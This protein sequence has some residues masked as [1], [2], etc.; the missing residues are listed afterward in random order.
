MLKVETGAI[1]ELIQDEVSLQVQEAL[2]DGKWLVSLEQRIT[3]F[4][5]G[6]ITKRFANID[7]VPDLVKSVETSVEK[8]FND[9]FIP[10]LHHLVNTS[11]L[12]NAVDTAIQ[13]QIATTIDQLIINDEWIKKIETLVNNNFARKIQNKIN[14]VDFNLLIVEQIDKGV[15]R[16]QDKLLDQL[17]TQG[18]DDQAS[19]NVL[20]LNDLGVDI[21]GELIADS[22]DIS[23][24]TVSNALVVNDLVVKNSVNTDSPKWD[25][26]KRSI[27]DKTLE[28]LNFEWRDSLV[29]QVLSDAETSGIEFDHVLVDGQP[30]VANHTLGHQVSKSSLQSVGVLNALQVAGEA[31]INNTMYVLSGRVGINTTSPDRALSIWDEEVAI[32]I[33]KGS[34]ETALIGTT[35]NH[36]LSFGVN[37]KSNIS[38]D[39]DGTTWLDKLKVDRWE[40]GTHKGVPGHS[41]TR[42]DILFNNDPKEGEAFCW[43]C[44]GGYKWKEVRL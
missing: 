16:W 33:G 30:L 43:Q 40:I 21:T 17:N 10:D 42:G 27:T 36:K 28:S 39:L 12:T 13:Q 1:E 22:A 19:K 5:Q 26:L 29:K 7:T 23:D 25:E 38:I 4:V 18:I 24:V 3:D 6:R 9:G 31:E 15:T 8:L 41:G 14:E 35:R 44:L 32:S 37:R 11:V 34:A 20:R 2:A